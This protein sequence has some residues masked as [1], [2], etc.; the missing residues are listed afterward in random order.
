MK[1]TALI[2]TLLLATLFLLASG[3]QVLAFTGSATDVGDGKWYYSETGTCYKL[4]NGKKKPKQAETRCENDGG[5]LV[6]ITSDEENEF[7]H[8]QFAQ[9]K[10]NVWIGL[11]DRDEEMEYRWMRSGAL[12]QK[13][14]W[15]DSTNQWYVVVDNYSNWDNGQPNDWPNK[16]PHTAHQQDYTALLANSGEWGDY[17]SNQKYRYVCEYDCAFDT[18]SITA[19]LDTN[20]GSISPSGTTEVLEGGNQTYNIQADTDYIIDYIEVDG[21]AIEIKDYQ[22]DYPF[23]DVDEDHTI[24]V[25]FMTETS[26]FVDDWVKWN[27]NGHCY[28]FVDNDKNINAALADCQSD[29]GYLVTIESAS[30][31][32]FLWNTFVNPDNEDA[33]IGA[34]DNNAICSNASDMHFVWMNGCAEMTYTGWDDN[35]FNQPNNSGGD[36]QYVV[37]R[38]DRGWDDRRGEDEHNYICEFDCSSAV[39]YDIDASAG[40]GGTISPSGTTSVFEH[41]NPVFT[42][43]ADDGYWISDVLVDGVSQ[44]IEGGHAL[45]HVINNVQSDMTIEAV[46]VNEYTVIDDGYGRH[47]TGN[48]YKEF[49]SKTGPLE[50]HA[51]CEGL[52]GYLVA[53]DSGG[54]NDFIFKQFAEGTG[55]RYWIGATDY[56]DFC[57]T[58]NEGTFVWM[59]DCTP[60]GYSNWNP[61]EPNDSGGEDYVEMYDDDGKW[62]DNGEYRDNRFVCEWDCTQAAV[63][64]IDLD[65]GT[66]GSATPSSDFK[67]PAN[68]DVT[69][70][71][72]AD[73]GY[74]I[75]LL[76]VNGNAV[77]AAELETDYSLDLDDILSNQTV[78]VQFRA[79]Y[80]D[81]GN[82]YGHFLHTDNCYKYFSSQVDVTTAH[83]TCTDWGGYLVEI[84]DDRENEMVH[85]YF[86]D[87]KNKSLWLGYTDSDGFCGPAMEGN[88]VTMSDCSP[89]SY[90][91]WYS[92]QP[93]NLGGTQDYIEMYHGWGGGWN[94]EYPNASNAFLCEWDCTAPATYTIQA[95]A[96]A[97]GAIDPDGNAAVPAGTTKSFDVQADT[98]FMINT[99]TVDG[100]SVSVNEPYTSYT[101]ENVQADHTIDATFCATVVMHGE[102]APTEV[103]PY[104]TSGRWFRILDQ[105]GDLVTGSA[106]DAEGWFPMAADVDIPCGTTS[107]TVEWHEVDAEHQIGWT[108]PSDMTIAIPGGG[109]SFTG[110]YVRT[111]FTLQMEKTGS[112]DYMGEVTPATGLHTFLY[113]QEV[114]IEA[115]KLSPCATFDGW[116]GLAGTGQEANADSYTVTFNVKEDRTVTADFGVNNPTVTMAVQCLGS[117]PSCPGTTDPL[118]GD[119]SPSCT[120]SP[121]ELTAYGNGWILDHWEVN[122]AP[123]GYYPEYD[124]ELDG[125]KDVVAVF[126]NVSD[127][128]IDHD[129]DGFSYNEGDC[130]PYDPDIHPGATEICGDGIDQDCDG[131]DPS[132][133]PG[134]TDSDG[135]G[136]TPNQGDCDDTDPTINPAA[137]DICGDGIDQNCYG[138][139]RACGAEVVCAD[140]SDVP[141]DTQI[142]PAPANVLFILDDSGSMDWE[143]MTTENEGKFEWEGYLY[144]SGFEDYKRRKWRSRWHGYNR[145]YYNPE[146][147][148]TPWPG[149]AD[150]SLT[151]P[152]WDPT[153]SG[154]YNMGNTYVYM[155]GIGFKVPHYFKWIDE[156]GDSSI[157]YGEIYLV[158]LDGSISYYRFN[159]NDG[160]GRVESGELESLP[161]G[162][163]PSALTP[164]DID[165]NPKTYTEE[166]QNFVNWFQYYRSRDLNAKAAISR[167]MVSLRHVN[168]GILTLHERVVQSLLPV[169]VTEGGTEQ[170]YTSDLL[171]LLYNDVYPSGGTPLRRALNNGG[172]YFDQDD[173]GKDSAGF[174]GNPWA[175]EAEGGACQ[176]SFII[177][178]TD[179]YYNGPDPPVGNED[180]D[181]DTAYDGGPF[182]DN[183]EKTLADVAMKYFEQD[184]V[185][186]LPDSVP[187]K[188]YS[189]YEEASHQ[190]VVLY[191]VAFGVTGSIDP[192]SYSNCP[193]DCPN[194]PY[195]FDSYTRRI[196][197]MW[198]AAVNGRGDFYSAGNP[199]QLVASLVAVQ[200]DIESKIG[201]G[202]SVSINAQE[203]QEGTV[204]YQGLYQTMTWSGDLRALSIDASTGDV[205]DSATWSAADL[206]DSR[207]PDT[208]NIFTS[209]GTS[210]YPFRYDS[211][212]ASQKAMLA[213]S[214]S[215]GRD[216]VAFIRG[217]SSKEIPSGGPYRDR[218]G[219]LA[220]IVHSAPNHYGDAL[221]VGANDGMLHAFDP[222][223]GQEKWAYIPSFCV[224]NL[225]ALADSAYVHQYYVDGDTY[226]GE[227][228]S[229]MYLVGALG[230]GGKG[231]Y[232]LDV[233]DP[234]PASEADAASLF[235]WEYPT[236]TDYDMGY[237]YSDAYIVD[238][239]VGDVVIF[240][241]GYDSYNARAFLYI[242]DAA[243]GSLLRKIDTLEGNADTVDCNGLSTPVLI[244]VDEDGKVDYVYAGDLLGNLWKFD[245]TS[246]SAADWKV[247]YGTT[248]NPEPLMRAKNA[249]GYRQPITASPD[250]MRHCDPEIP[251]YIVVF[252]TGRYLGES[253]YVNVNQ[254]SVYGVWDWEDALEDVGADPTGYHLGTF[255]QPAGTPPLRTFSNLEM[256]PGTMGELTLQQQQTIYNMNN[257][258]V[259]SDNEMEWYDPVTGTGDHVGWY[260]N[261]PGTAERISQDVF[262]R[263]GKAIFISSMPSGA[264]CGAGGNSVIHEVDAC[265]GGRTEKPQLDVN[266]DNKINDQDLINVPD[267]DNP[268]GTIDAAPTAVQRPGM[269]YPPAILQM[270]FGD[271]ERKYFSTSLGSISMLDEEAETRGIYYW[272]ELE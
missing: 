184:L 243:T 9:G 206:L 141:M 234:D 229:S 4:F 137:T 213:S 116:L 151:N 210:A 97:G 140:L 162:T 35:P 200:R 233:T 193:P 19:S 211:L 66:N 161:V 264:R 217:D 115:A 175:S 152:K 16:Y 224:E 124:L 34:T 89:M 191:T 82:D 154:T 250:V 265:T 176:Q 8:E 232:C 188:T 128:D 41:A 59:R 37:I 167:V 132:C 268:G 196:D 98:G 102:V 74:V 93:N 14:E 185:S 199:Q 258:R 123:V 174:G 195:P 148:Y 153:S 94:D 60:I 23:N 103:G 58:A 177:L 117:P 207:D 178:M 91:A 47:Y 71:F 114:T 49:T 99:L 51:V 46:F 228:G 88:F 247:S 7:V 100:T 86:V 218:D 194:W 61:G 267:P 131:V 150:A 165:G 220:D 40:T 84:Q 90:E 68:S 239:S 78:V 208:R 212:T 50:A 1:R 127:D 26:P 270:P 108:K 237:S 203:L 240:G 198:H 254:Q 6:E 156:D 13:Q 22:A 85:E 83:Q 223:T 164:K 172:E 168:V 249:D 222:D 259:L 45:D 110:T 119:Y 226:V 64:E 69:L 129:G 245:L 231:Y 28:R 121:M 17:D 29:G 72:E 53:I 272:I 32:D 179:G 55:E 101:F 122:G 255:Q 65:V 62:N 215:V 2:P 79:E 171:D 48:C 216:I 80:Q 36:Q 21:S 158:Y 248:S 109:T 27:V 139:D 138:G 219:V 170:D 201:S 246:G 190:H 186:A 204:V 130:M 12:A 225:S 44:P 266:Q 15:S 5:Y 163:Q 31:D 105:N 169:K 241:N 146:V 87:P 135:D 253:D 118:P 180:G 144:S 260:Y 182:A 157:D 263:D 134:D 11:T 145:V 221:F 52:G 113:D 181:N 75:S 38:T 125:D 261:L 56:W 257:V 120:D 18:H 192:D 147:E 112:G 25:H 256:L 54:E 43:E 251:G 235:K 95:T 3:S 173:G 189:I 24:V 205:A 77:P 209:D 271:I 160:D 214:D 63:Y 92:S 111:G 187:S 269:F 166:R 244:D 126:R 42:I 107:I 252:G 39:M 236:G 133:G 76:S 136:F 104:N 30:E 155:D 242:L 20:N 10:G 238:S 67:V 159:D 96:G 57:P 143:F 197:D 262:I 227:V 33:W 106:S 183:Y 70:Y 73:D 202:A 142:R 230:K 149:M 81:I